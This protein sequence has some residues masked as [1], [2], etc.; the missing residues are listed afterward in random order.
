MTSLRAKY[1]TKPIHNWAKGVLPALSQTESEALTAGEVWW[2]AELFSGNP[3]WKKLHAV[4]APKLTNEEQAFLDGPCQELCGM[5]DDWQINQEDG[6]LPA[7][8]WQFLRD[9][10]FFGMIIPKSHGG[11]EFSA[12]TSRVTTSSPASAI[13]PSKVS[14]DFCSSAG[15]RVNRTRCPM[16][17][18]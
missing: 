16:L 6:D 14:P 7:E 2:E 11:L 10:K 12:S 1:V 17:R 13:R 9:K 18:R 15:L 3:D 5:I 8:V 4:K